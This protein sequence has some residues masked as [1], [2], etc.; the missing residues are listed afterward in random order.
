VLSFNLAAK[1]SSA[2][3]AMAPNGT[4][5]IIA[6]STTNSDFGVG[7][8]GV[9]DRAGQYLDWSGQDATISSSGAPALEGGWGATPAK[10]MLKFDY[11][12]SISLRVVD[13]DHFEIHNDSTAAATGS[14]WILTQPTSQT[15]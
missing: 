8:L 7:Y 6:T 9:V 15:P 3:I 12:S 4:A 1:S 10:I 13:S 5:F 14:I 11:N 2:P